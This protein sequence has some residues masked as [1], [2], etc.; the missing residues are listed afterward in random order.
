MNI[1]RIHAS[2]RTQY[3]DLTDPK[4]KF[5]KMLCYSIS[6][7]LC[8]CRSETNCSGIKFWAKKHDERFS[9]KQ[10]WNDRPSL[11]GPS[12]IYPNGTIEWAK[13][14]KIHRRWQEGP[15]FINHSI[16][17]KCDWSGTSDSTCDGDIQWCENGNYH[18]P[19]SEG[20]AFIAKNGL[21]MWFVK[22]K[23]FND[24]KNK[25]SSSVNIFTEEDS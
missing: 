19:L 1:L 7:D 23:L 22:G 21:K 4:Y 5:G 16:Y 13:N 11:E 2:I 6:H 9:Y 3:R 18:R 17:C 20:P 24:P 14:G 8:C 10:T 12:I 15:A 25:K